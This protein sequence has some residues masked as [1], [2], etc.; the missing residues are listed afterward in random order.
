EYRTAG[1]IIILGAGSEKLSSLI[2]VERGKQ[3]LVSGGARLGDVDQPGH[4]SI[5][6]VFLVHIRDSLGRAACSPAGEQAKAR[7]VKVQPAIEG[8]GPGRS[9][10]FHVGADNLVVEFLSLSKWLHQLRPKPSPNHFNYRRAIHLRVGDVA[11]IQR[12]SS[13]REGDKIQ[14]LLNLHQ[15]ERVGV[16]IWVVFGRRPNIRGGLCRDGCSPS[17]RDGK[18]N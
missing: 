18:G 4:P 9:Q 7:H 8:Y 13:V 6:L 17:D 5:G 16:A 1:G 14:F 2:L 12:R 10:E 11:Y 15:V 3:K